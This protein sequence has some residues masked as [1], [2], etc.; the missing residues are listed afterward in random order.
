MAWQHSVRRTWSGLAQLVAPVACVGCA[1]PGVDLCPGCG[2]GLT[3]AA[4]WTRPVPC[5]RGMPRVATV[6]AYEGAVRAA[7]I[8]LKEDGRTGLRAPMA[9]ALTAAV[10][11]VLLEAADPCRV[12][13]VPVP[14]SPQALRARDTDAVE[15]LAGTASR[16]LRAAGVDARVDL[17]L[18]PVRRRADQAGLSSAARAANLAGSLRALP[19]EVPVVVVDDVVTTGATL[20]ESARALAAAGVPVLG[21]ATVAA[22]A[23]R[24]G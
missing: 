8:A 19:C 23:R 1:R 20:V 16:L 7:V 2:A 5:P 9:A 21:A 13:L 17:V 15:D 12:R 18:R 4:R 24:C 14:S 3:A 10:G 6:A 22:T 11:L